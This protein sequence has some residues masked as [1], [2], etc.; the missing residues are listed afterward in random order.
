MRML[1]K[2]YRRDGR[3]YAE[4]VICAQVWN[5]AKGQRVPVLGYICPWCEAR[6]RKDGKKNGRDIT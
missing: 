6:I 5:I 1:R 3:R 4:C 2:S